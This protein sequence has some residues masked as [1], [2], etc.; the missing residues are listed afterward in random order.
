VKKRTFGKREFLVKSRVLLI[1][2]I[3]RDVALQTRHD[4]SPWVRGKDIACSVRATCSERFR[5]RVVVQQRSENKY[6]IVDGFGRVEAAI[7]LGWTE[8]EVDVLSRQISDS[9]VL[10]IALT[11]NNG[12]VS[13]KPYSSQEL[14]EN[15]YRLSG[16][17]HLSYEQIATIQE[18]PLDTVKHRVMRGK[19]I[20]DARAGDD[21]LTRIQPFTN[22]R[23]PLKAATDVLNA[24]L[25]LDCPTYEDVC[26]TFRDRFNIELRV[27]VGNNEKMVKGLV[28]ELLFNEELGGPTNFLVLL[29][30]QKAG[31]DT[32][33]ARRMAERIVGIKRLKTLGTFYFADLSADVA[34]FNNGEILKYV[35]SCRRQRRNTG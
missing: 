15:A 21:D 3:N 1:A 10:F 6:R 12:H 9:D 20:A 8:L 19:Q 33:P 11:A 16:E 25:K 5:D 13:E 14:Q 27:Y 26:N 2:Q 34:N 29:C 30:V 28:A 7:L 4:D 24:A 31:V 32:A 22:S 18:V 23:A 35:E 17:L